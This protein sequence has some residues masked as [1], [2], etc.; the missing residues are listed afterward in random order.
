MGFGHAV[1][2]HAVDDH[3][4]HRAIERRRID[5]VERHGPAVDEQASESFAAKRFDRRRDR[6]R[7][8]AG[9]LA[10]VAGAF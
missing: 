3:V 8:G 10:R 5:V 2:L 1:Q 6:R 4:Q 7:S 9:R